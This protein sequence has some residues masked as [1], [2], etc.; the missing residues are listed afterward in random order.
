MEAHLAICWSHLVDH[1]C[2]LQSAAVI[3]RLGNVVRDRARLTAAPVLHNSH[4]RLDGNWCHW[5]AVYGAG[6]AHLIA[7]AEAFYNVGV[8]T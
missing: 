5:H 4:G 3:R 7:L 6:E 1:R 2:N 8:T